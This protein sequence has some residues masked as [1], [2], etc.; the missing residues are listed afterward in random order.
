MGH[1]DNSNNSSNYF[2]ELTESTPVGLSALGVLAHHLVAFGLRPRF[3]MLHRAHL[4]V[5]TSRASL[6]NCQEAGEQP[7]TLERVP[8]AYQYI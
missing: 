2:A 6:E 7:C 4:R 8:H 5:K 3:I 1:D